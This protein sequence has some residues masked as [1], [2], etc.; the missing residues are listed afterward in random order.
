VGDFLKTLAGKIASG[1]VALAVA[2]AGLA[3]YETDPATKHAILSLSGRILGWCLLMLIVPWASFALIGW[4]GK[5][6][7]NAAGAV[8]VLAI[9]IADAIVLAWL[10]SW[11]IR[12]ATEWV[13]FTAAVLIGGVY[14]LFTCDLI[15]EKME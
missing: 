2:G 13:L 6:R 1:V 10:F 8:L 7:S 15:A 12:G 9:T 11:S 3:W 4:V 5:M 14:N